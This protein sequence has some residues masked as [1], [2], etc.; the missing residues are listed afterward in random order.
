VA[1][2]TCKIEANE[3][4]PVAVILQSSPP[5]KA[6]V[7]EELLFP[8]ARMSP[9]VVSVPILMVLAAVPVPK[10]TVLALL[11]VPKLTVPVVP[12]SRA[13][14]EDVVEEIDNE[15]ESEMVLVPKV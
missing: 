6:K 12:E 11:P 10:L 7:V 3:A 4:K 9:A 2:P 13:I 1:E 15:P 14:S 8:I 5:V